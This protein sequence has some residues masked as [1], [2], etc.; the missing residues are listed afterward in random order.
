MK[1]FRRKNEPPWEVVGCEIV[2]PVFMFDGG[3]ELDVVRVRGIS[4][5]GKYIFDFKKHAP[6]GA[7]GVSTV[8]FARQQLMQEITKKNYNILLLEGWTLTRL[9]QGKH[10]RI[11]VDYTGRPG[12]VSGKPP[13]P[14]PPPFIAVLEGRHIFS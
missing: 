2:E 1:W 8:L 14:R 11:E 6:N 5:S 9:R 12:Y 3:D 4:M 10:H 13:A 7:Q